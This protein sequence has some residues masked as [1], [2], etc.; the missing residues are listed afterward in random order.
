MRRLRYW[1]QKVLPLVYDDSLSYYELL[2]KVVWKINEMIGVVEK[3]EGQIEDLYNINITDAVGDILKEWLEDGTLENLLLSIEDPATSKLFFPN[4][5]RETYYSANM[6]VLNSYGKTFILDCGALQNWLACKELLDDLFADGTITNIDYIIISHYHFDHMGNIAN[7]LENYPHVGCKVYTAMSPSGY[8]QGEDADGLVGNYNTVVSACT[9]AGV[10]LYVVNSD[11]TIHYPEDYSIPYFTLINSNANDYAYYAGIG[12]VYNNYCMVATF[13]IDAEIVMFSADIQ[14]DAQIHFME[15]KDVPQCEIYSAHHHGIQNDDYIPFLNAIT[16]RFLMVQT[17]GY[18]INVSARS[19]FVSNYYTDYTTMLTN[20]FGR[21]TFEIYKTGCSLIEGI[22][23]GS[24]GDYMSY[25]DIYVDNST[26]V[27]GDGT[28]EHPV[29]SIQTALML[30]NNNINMNYR[31]YIKATGIDYD[32]VFIRNRTCSITLNKWGDSKPNVKYIY[33]GFDNELL[34]YNLRFTGV[35][36]FQGV[37]SQL[38]ANNMN[39]LYVSS[40]E[41][42]MSGETSR[43]IGIMI[44][45]STVYAVGNSFVGDTGNVN[46]HGA[47]SYRYGTLITNGNDFEDLIDAYDTANLKV[48]VRNVDTLTNVGTYLVGDVTN[49]MAVEFPAM[50]A[51]LFNSLSA[52]VAQNTTS[53]SSNLFYSQGALYTLFNK[54]FRQVSLV[55]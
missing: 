37:N 3:I 15:T 11:L 44:A 42:D 8:Y 51:D 33:A 2:N 25:V 1:V 14:R 27:L 40:C 39:S 4:L 26:G 23:L 5:N 36:A 21:V 49:G 16:P 41:F 52:L 53:V 6:A 22:P 46:K 17:S 47:R 24:M 45:L 32:G 50:S 31:I 38:I 35:R 30:C 43:T 7:I 12:S 34:I 18:R 54:Q 10:E 20:A 28:Q 19:S 55:E 9:T 13:H 48:I 29:N